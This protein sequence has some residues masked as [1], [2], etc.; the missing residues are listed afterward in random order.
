MTRTKRT[1]IPTYL[2]VKNWERLRWTEAGEHQK[3]KLVAELG[4]H[5]KGRI[6]TVKADYVW[7]QAVLQSRPR[8]P[9]LTRKP[10]YLLV[11]EHDP[12]EQA[13]LWAPQSPPLG[14]LQRVL[15]EKLDCK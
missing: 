11:R 6:R 5:E 7:G 12:A 10:E 8:H 9:G 13:F 1:M 3:P 14:P 15:K 4:V 2:T